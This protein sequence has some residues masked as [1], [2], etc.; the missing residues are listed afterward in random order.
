MVQGGEAEHPR[1]GS[2]RQADDE[3]HPLFPFSESQRAPR[4][5]SRR[6]R[7]R[8]PMRFSPLRSDAGGAEASAARARSVRLQANIEV[9]RPPA[10]R[11]DFATGHLAIY[12]LQAVRSPSGYQQYDP[13][14]RFIGGIRRRRMSGF[15]ARRNPTPVRCLS[16]I[17]LQG[18]DV[19]S[20]ARV[21]RGG[22][23]IRWRWQ[24]AL[25]AQACE[26]G[27][28]NIAVMFERHAV[29]DEEKD[30]GST[31]ATDVAVAA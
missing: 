31:E 30:L 28:T 5:P 24:D 25:V 22:T 10:P 9:P 14:P 7:F 8:Q 1:R 26:F 3:R 29:D 18:R 21:G 2:H 6:S 20:M 23:A 12:E 4:W 13:I 27:G 15:V 19:S 17:G 16:A 11:Q